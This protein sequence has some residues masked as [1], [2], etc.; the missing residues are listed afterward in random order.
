MKRT[1]EQLKMLKYDFK[2][3]KSN[4][5]IN[6]G[7]LLD[8]NQ[9]LKMERKIMNINM[10]MTEE[11]KHEIIYNRNKLNLFYAKSP[12]QKPRQLQMHDNAFKNQ[13]NFIIYNTLT[14]IL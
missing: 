5:L 10:E 3:Q 13:V 11:M 6:S 14:L 1:T 7:I 9:G 4:E 2:I 8:V 12:L